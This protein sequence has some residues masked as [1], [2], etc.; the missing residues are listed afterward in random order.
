MAEEIVGHIRATFDADGATRKR[1]E[2]FLSERQL[3]P[4]FMM[5]LSEV[6]MQLQDPVTQHAAAVFFKNTVKKFWNPEEGNGLAPSEKEAIKQRIV[7]MV[8]QVSAKS[9]EHLIECVS[10]IS[11]HDFHE[12]WQQLLPELTSILSNALSGNDFNKVAQVLQ[13]ANEVFKKFRYVYKSDPLFICLK[14]CLDNFQEPVTVVFKAAHDVIPRVSQD[15]DA[16]TVVVKVLRLCA[17]IFFSLN[18]Q[19]IPEYFEDNIGAWMQTTDNLIT[20]D[21]AVL[22]RRGQELE[23]EHPTV[24]AELKAA[25]I[26]NVALYVEKYEEELGDH[27]KPLTEHIYMLLMSLNR[28]VSNDQLA[29]RGMHFLTRLVKKQ[30]NA[31]LFHDEA[32]S[33]ILRDVVVPNLVFREHEEQLFDMSPIEFVQREMEG[34]DAETR[35]RGAADLVRGMCE[36]YSAKTTQICGEYVMRLLQEYESNPESEWRKKEAALALIQAVAV[37]KESRRGVKEVNENLNVMDVF[38][39]HVLPELSAAAPNVRPL[40][41][42]AAIKFAH[43]FRRQMSAEQLTI[44]ARHYVAHMSGAQY[45]ALQT[46]ACISF[47]KIFTL[48][49]YEQPGMPLVVPPEALR[50]S[51]AEAANAIF[52]TLNNDDFPQNDHA[53]KALMR[54]IIAAGDQLQAAYPALMT[55]MLD[56]L[57]GICSGSLTNAKFGHCLFE[58]IAV[59][60]RTVCKIDASHIKKFEEM[61]WPPFQVILNR[62]I[63]EVTPYVFQVL[64]QMCEVYRP[65]TIEPGNKFWEIFPF[66]LMPAVWVRRSNFPALTRLL[67]AIVKRGADHIVAQRQL[68]PVLGVSQKLLASASS[69]ESAYALLLQVV[70]HVNVEALKAYIGEIFNLLLRRMML[71]QNNLRSVRRMSYFLGVFVTKFGSGHLIDVLEQVQQ[72]LSANVTQNVWIANAAA[73]KG[74]SAVERKTFVNGLVKMLFESPLL[75]GNPQIVAYGVN[76]ALQILRSVGE[77]DGATDEPEQEI[78]YDSTFSKLQYTDPV[79]EDFF[80]ALPDPD[81]FLVKRLEDFC[82]KNPGQ[83]GALIQ[84]HL[85]QEEQGTLQQLCQKYNVR[86]S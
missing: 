70:I 77:K 39:A 21:F 37:R 83:F 18:Y 8:M 26:E 12:Q 61:L 82:G 47:E 44:L 80:P 3:Q 74:W 35:R 25:L 78:A 28:R 46:Y 63:E 41:K 81:A 66:L 62:D 17:R 84:P 40:V 71:N 19:D 76:A 48:R 22:E 5:Q 6:I 54:C 15:K 59:I 86:L 34:S 20:M 31:H 68:E 65:G 52:E 9:G 7:T 32:L 2:A 49:H 30:A 38:T 13:V 55:N 11:K 24:Q 57:G 42:A 67:S 16:L 72:G 10:L 85:G 51:L 53:M 27:C 14:Y 50:G 1:G 4:G 58:S 79:D 69:E 45:A 56:I 29:I 33:A 64:A 43:T 60:I 75:Q 73:H 23:L 36:L